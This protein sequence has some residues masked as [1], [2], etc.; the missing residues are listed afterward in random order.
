MKTWKY[1]VT[2]YLN[3]ADKNGNNT[4]VITNPI[5]CKGTI[6]RKIF[7]DSNEATID[8]YNLSKGTRDKIYQDPYQLFEN[9]HQIAIEVGYTE[10]D[11]MSLVFYGVVMQAYSM[12]ASGS[13]EVIT[14]IKALCLDLF[15]LSS[16]T[17]EAGT[18]KRDAIKDLAQ[19]LPNV[20]LN[21]LGDISG[22]FLTTT[23]FDGNTLEQINKIAG[24][25]AFIDNK[26]LNVC[27][28]NEALDVPVPIISNDSILLETPVRRDLTLEVNSIMLPELLLGQLLQI[29]AKIFT[30]FNGQY[31]VIGFT[32]NFLISESVE[33]QKTTKATLHIGDSLPFADISIT[34]VDNKMQNRFTKVKQ[35]T[36]IPVSES[37]KEAVIQ[38][39]KYIQTHKGQVPPGYVIK[40]TK[41]SGLS[42]SWDAFLGHSN[43]PQERLSEVN[44]TTLSNIYV[45]AQNA[46]R[47]LSKYY[48]GKKISI[49]SGWRSVRNNASVG[50]EADS[51]HLKGLAM[52]FHIEGVP[53][54][55]VEAVMLKAW[56]GGIG[57]VYKNIS[58]NFVHIQIDKTTKLVNDV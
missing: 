57:Y 12:H 55:Q 7:S 14:K 11:S 41:N 43:Q 34:G 22:N 35:E 58:K 24:G 44:I 42:M 40:G 33:G 29:E 46:F 19:D 6:T 15:N 38:V 18:S 45:L 32:H 4:I 48:G 21:A 54:S 3:N 1:R 13:T 8:L 16:R 27:L 56:S 17:F 49:T 51:K 25:T 47:V 37:T 52:D 10:D 9:R 39:Y 53:L 20:S 26:D 2:I 31:K 30:D 5:A 36:I 28:I 23:T 50:G